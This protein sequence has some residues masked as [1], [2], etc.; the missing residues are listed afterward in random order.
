MFSVTDTYVF[1]LSYYLRY[2]TAYSHLPWEMRTRA[3]TNRGSV[4]LIE[5]EILNSDPPTPLSYLHHPRVSHGP[6]TVSW[7]YVER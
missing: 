2:K 1:Y 4:D 7:S 6:Q 5:N 3:R